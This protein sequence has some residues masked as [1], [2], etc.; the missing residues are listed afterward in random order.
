MA[1]MSISPL[2]L[3]IALYTTHLVALASDSESGECELISQS[4]CSGLSMI[5]LSNKH[6][7]HNGAST[8][9]EAKAAL[10]EL[11][12]I[13]RKARPSVARK[14]L[15]LSLLEMG[16]NVPEVAVPSSRGA[17]A[18]GK[19]APGPAAK[20]AAAFHEASDKQSSMIS[21]PSGQPAT[22]GPKGNAPSKTSSPDSNSG[23]APSK[24][25]EVSP[26]AGVSGTLIAPFG[27]EDVAS[28]LTNHAA[29]TQDVLVDAVE[30][31]EVAEVKR[32]VFRAL[33]RLRAASIKEFDTIARL[34]TQAIDEY[35]DNHHYRTENP[36]N[37]LHS[38]EPKPKEDKFT[39]FH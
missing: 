21:Q 16:Y 7:V 15:R 24:A 34:E 30:N 26:P 37:Y 11:K 28:E 19:Q 31:A 17:A 27:K 20:G 22:T 10:A 33:T 39:S 8:K 2:I 23:T 5:Q 13:L 36:L 18:P 6:L 32:A 25:P 35:N 9:A 12:Q 38:D 14:A 1:A 29:R 4:S 3:C